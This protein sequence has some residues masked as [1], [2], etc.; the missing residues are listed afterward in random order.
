MKASVLDSD[1]PTSEIHKWSTRKL[2]EWSHHL[3]FQSINE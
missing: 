2:E 3:V 1:V